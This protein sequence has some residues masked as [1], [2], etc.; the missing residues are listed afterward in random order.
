MEDLD[1]GDAIDYAGEMHIR[2]WFAG[3][4]LVG[5]LSNAALQGEREPDALALGPAWFAEQA[6]IQADAMLDWRE[7]RNE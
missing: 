6:W 3:Q 4:A 5:L 1:Y 2:D 7:K